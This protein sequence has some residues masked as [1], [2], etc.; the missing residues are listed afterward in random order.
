MRDMFDMITNKYMVGFFI[1]VLAL[2]VLSTNKV[3]NEEYIHQEDYST[4]IVYK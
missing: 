1:T 3:I 4:I 2:G